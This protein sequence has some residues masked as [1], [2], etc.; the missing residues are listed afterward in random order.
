MKTWA[1]EVRP[2]LIS[3]VYVSSV[4]ACGPKHIGSRGLTRSLFTCCFE[5]ARVPS[6]TYY[7]NIGSRG[8]ARSVFIALCFERAHAAR[9]PPTH[10]AVERVGDPTGG[11]H[12]RML[13]HGHSRS[14]GYEMTDF[15]LCVVC[16]ML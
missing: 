11:V 8:L 9:N 14:R 10:S 15:V 13:M 16:L 12:P 7:E 3:E 1:P 2:S 5:C 4:G 6:E